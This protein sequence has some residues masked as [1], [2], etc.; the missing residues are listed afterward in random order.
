MEAAF[1]RD[2]LTLRDRSGS[3]A[4]EK[5]PDDRNVFDEERMILLR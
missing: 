2:I 4:N 5:G 1:W 3:A